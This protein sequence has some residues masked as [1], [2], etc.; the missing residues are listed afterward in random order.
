MAAGRKLFL[1][2]QDI[3][4]DYVNYTAHKK[5]ALKNPLLAH[6]YEAAVWLDY[7]PQA[8]FKIAIPLSFGVTVVCDRYL[9]DTVI[10]D[11]AVHL[12][13]DSDQIRRSLHSSFRLLPRP[14]QAFLIDL[15]E[16][17]AIQ[18]KNDVPH[19]DYLRERRALYL[20][21]GELYPMFKLD[22]QE[23][24]QKLIGQI[25]QRIGPLF[26]QTKGEHDHQDPV[27]GH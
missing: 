10:G 19:L 4:Q 20:R 24:P 2:K 23:K 9:F 18:R 13:Y 7:F 17:I 22:G 16:E 12:N 5:F 25:V 1:R 3:W 6:I 11:L 15:P 21:L 8:F 27:F 14:D 26:E